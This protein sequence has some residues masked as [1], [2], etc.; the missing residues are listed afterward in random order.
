LSSLDLEVVDL[1][2]KAADDGADVLVGLE[3]AACGREGA[4][5]V[6]SMASSVTPASRG[7]PREGVDG[8][9]AG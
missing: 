5:R 2:I 9:R 8:A 1:P 3:L 4:S 6:A 7:A